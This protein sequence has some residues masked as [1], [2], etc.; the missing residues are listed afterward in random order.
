MRGVSWQ[1]NQDTPKCNE[2]GWAKENCGR[3]SADEE[4]GEI[5]CKIIINENEN[6][7]EGHDN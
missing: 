3:R 6:S 5:R 4:I 2:E 7:D 1:I